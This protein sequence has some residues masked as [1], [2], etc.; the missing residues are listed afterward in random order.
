MSKTKRENNTVCIALAKYF[1]RSLQPKSDR[2]QKTIPFRI[3]K[4]LY[5]EECPNPFEVFFDEVPGDWKFFF[6]VDVGEYSLE[7]KKYIGRVSFFSIYTKLNYIVSYRWASHLFRFTTELSYSVDKEGNVLDI[8]MI[9]GVPER[10]HIYSVYM[11]LG[12]IKRK[13]LVAAW[14]DTNRCFWT[15]LYYSEYCS[16]RKM[17]KEMRARLSKENKKKEREQK[18]S[19]KLALFVKKS[20]EKDLKAAGT[21]G[22][23]EILDYG[24]NTCPQYRLFVVSDSLR[25]AGNG[26]PE[27]LDLHEEDKKEFYNITDK[28]QKKIDNSGF[29]FCYTEA[30]IVSEE[31]YWEKVRVSTLSSGLSEYERSILDWKE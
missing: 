27:C 30:D 23:I 16:E 26:I 14:I 12:A 20:L 13:P 2:E 9:Y 11:I 28:L 10:C 19:F 1:L 4:V 25:A 7:K 15:P 5:N 8:D 6:D 24:S 3:E 17:K 18:W 21:E 22:R 29:P 31:E